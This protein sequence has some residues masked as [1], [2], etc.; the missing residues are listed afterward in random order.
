MIHLYTK[1]ADIRHT[2]HGSPQ[3]TN[4]Y[5]KAA[6]IS[7]AVPILFVALSRGDCETIEQICPCTPNGM[8][9]AKISNNPETSK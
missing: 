5:G 1:G 6:P 3:T 9:R 2:S 4:R 7:G 8:L